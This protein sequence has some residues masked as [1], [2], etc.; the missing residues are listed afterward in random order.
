MQPNSNLETKDADQNTSSMVQEIEELE[1]QRIKIALQIQD[2]EVRKEKGL[3]S[4]DD[5]EKL[6]SL[7]VDNMDI[8]SNINSLS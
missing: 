7:Y 3:F 8:I 2:L 6:Q 1:A 5:A 4:L